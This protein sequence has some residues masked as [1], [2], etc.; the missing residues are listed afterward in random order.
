MQRWQNYNPKSGRTRV[1]LFSLSSWT[2]GFWWGSLVDKR[3][4]HFGLD[5]GPL[6]IT[7][8]WKVSK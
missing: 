1:T 5:L 6:A 2:F 8:S 4:K 7:W 3:K